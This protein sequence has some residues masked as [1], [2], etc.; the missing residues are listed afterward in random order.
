MTD[1]DDDYE[2]ARAIRKLVLES[3]S[4]AGSVSPPEGGTPMAVFANAA[5]RGVWSYWARPGLDLKYRVASAITIMV[6][7]RQP[8]DVETFV[9]AALHNGWL[10]KDEIIELVLQSA[11]Y[12]GYP[13]AR[14]A[15]GAV[16][17][18]FAESGA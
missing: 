18:V 3:G 6:A 13:A 9:R 8:T 11:P 1:T 4:R 14:L 5:T 7:L 17:R 16:D 12:L 15:M 2:R 10:S